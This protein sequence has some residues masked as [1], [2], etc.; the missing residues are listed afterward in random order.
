MSDFDL[1]DYKQRKTLK[2]ILCRLG[3]D[4]ERLFGFRKTT[5]LTKDDILYLINSNNKIKSVKNNIKE[6][7]SF[8]EEGCFLETKK[9]EDLQKESELYYK[10]YAEFQKLNK[11]IE[12]HNIDKKV[13]KIK[14]KQM[15]KDLN[16]GEEEKIVKEESDKFLQKK[17]EKKKSND[18]NIEI[19]NNKKY[20]KE[21][22][23]YICRLEYD[24]RKPHFFYSNLCPT[25][26]A[27]NYQFRS[28]E[29][30]LT[31]RIAVVTGGRVKI[32]F[33]IVKKL[34]SYNAKV[35]MTTRFPVD[36][37]NR[38]KME[39]NYNKWKNNINIYPIDFRFFE[40]TIKFAK[41]LNEN[42]SHIDILINNAAQ[43]VRRDHHYYKYLL[44]NEETSKQ[45]EKDNDDIIIKNEYITQVHSNI[46]PSS[47]KIYHDTS[48][49]QSENS[50]KLIKVSMPLSVAASQMQLLPSNVNVAQN[51]PI[52]FDNNLLPF[53]FSINKTS[54]NYEIDEVPFA[55][56]IEVQIINA[57]TPYYLNVVLKPLFM[58][59]PFHDKY[60]VNVTSVEG[61]FNHFKKTTHPHTNMAKASLNMMTR[62]CGKYYKKFGIY[63]TC[64]DTGWVSPMNPISKI[65]QGEEEKKDFENEFCNIPLDELDGAM[66]VIH[67]VIE[68]VKNK[69]YLFGCLLKNYRRNDW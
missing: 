3:S 41:Y 13:A 14:E 16:N 55:E 8:V 5:N 35:I 60:I 61:I 65:F 20:Q 38:L 67:P 29:I 43:T 52:L 57:W 4:L 28:M 27:Y 53:D 21:T 6:I 47:E 22:K 66:R 36:C 62:T 64:V 17:R 19:V 18:D 7:F 40:S 37:L 12:E 48:I 24:Y 15:T 49:N 59:S 34:L 45:N 1:E 32:G 30:D 25:C 31:G 33:E 11:Y 9:K 46:L 54:W 23:C 63:M 2:S 39:S 51:L 44:S 68:G 26:A 50:D 69:N 42:Y 10:R 56:F 58:K